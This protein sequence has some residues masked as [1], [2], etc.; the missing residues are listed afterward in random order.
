[1]NSE[2]CHSREGCQ[3]TKPSSQPSVR[4]VMAST[5]VSVWFPAFAGTNISNRFDLACDYKTLRKRRIQRGQHQRRHQMHGRERQCASEIAIVHQHHHLGAETGKGRQ[6]TRKPVT[7]NIR[8]SGDSSGFAARCKGKADEKA[9]NR[10][11]GKRPH[12]IQLRPFIAKRKP[13]ACPRTEQH[14]TD[15]NC[16]ECCWHQRMNCF[17]YSAPSPTVL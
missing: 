1:M 5:N 13:V 11:G 8:H 15:R 9:A 6:R 3:T 16:R 4:I 2:H 10:I 7:K 12:G 17:T 14:C